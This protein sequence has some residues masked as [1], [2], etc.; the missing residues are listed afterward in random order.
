MKTALISIVL[1]LSVSFAAFA[2]QVQFSSKASSTRVGVGEPFQLQ[3]TID[4]AQNISGFQPP[5]FHGFSILSQSQS[6]STSIINGQMS[7]SISFLFIL[8]ATSPGNYTIPGAK[9]RVNGNS[10]MSNP[11]SIHVGA[12]GPSRPGQQPIPS[13]VSP[14]NSPASGIQQELNSNPGVLKMGENARD[15]IKKNVFVKVDVDKKNVYVGQQITASYKLYTRL[16][17]SSNVTKV[18]S[19]SGF[20]AHDLNLPNPPQATTEQ[21]NGKTFKVFTIRKTMLFPMQSGTLELDPVEV[22]NTVRLYHVTKHKSSGDPFSDL[23]NDPFFKD[24]FGSDPMF[25]D[26]FG[27]NVTYQ[28]YTYNITSTPIPIHVKPLP[29]KG[30]PANFSGAVGQYSISASVDKNSLSTSDAGTLTVTVSGT[31]NINLLSAPAIPFPSSFESYDPKITDKI[32]NQSNPYGGSRTF[33]YAFM[34]RAAGTY[35][36]PPIQFSYFD[37]GSG[38]YKTVQTEPIRIAVTPGAANT[39]D[40]GVAS[41]HLVHNNT[42]APILTGDIAWD[43]SADS[44]A[45]QF[46]YWALLGLPLVLLAFMVWL[47]KH[48]Q[49]DSSGGVPARKKKANKTALARLSTANQ[50]L[51]QRKGKEFYEEVS[52]ALWGYLCDKLD[53][54]YA[55]LSREKVQ[56]ALQARQV[57]EQDQRRLFELLDTCEMALYAASVSLGDMHSVYN[58][59]IQ[60][61]SGLEEQLKS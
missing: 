34:P 51:Q 35:T 30:K 46:W 29:D 61:I 60:L 41:A 12:A 3:Y 28:D 31:G 25:D 9:A 16:P 36:L 55:E 47:R 56:R 21:L 4:N 42:L 49:S 50:F 40:S 15:K 2:Q 13:P 14:G 59:A 32:N 27:N 22:D 6:N 48:T 23:F 57:N 20:S 52:T 45:G 43:T 11:V 5:E 10:M 33:S 24:P 58:T 8:S 38:T 7:Q 17:T 19:Y 18:P 1:F 44:R 53:I 54:V 26:P 37:P 39:E